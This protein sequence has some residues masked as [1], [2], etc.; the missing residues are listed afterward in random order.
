[1]ADHVAQHRPALTPLLD[2]FVQEAKFARQSI[3]ARLRELPPGAAILEVGAGLMLM[4]CHLRALGYEVHALEPIGHGFSGFAEL[5]D[6]VLAFARSRGVGPRV[7]PIPVEDLQ[8]VSRYDFAFSLNVMEHVGSVP[9]AIACVGRAL[10]PGASYL[11]I[12]PNYLFPYEPHFNMP[13]LGSKRLTEKVLGRRI[14]ASKAV[15][16]PQGTWHSLNWINVLQVGRVCRKHTDLACSFDRT[17]LAT[18]FERAAHDPGFA[19]R[20]GE[21]IAWVASAIVRSGLS[22]ALRFLPAA[23]QPVMKCTLTKAGA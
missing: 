17:L 7:L 16:D 19:A 4:S 10:R 2:V 9:E 5:Q 6:V 11:F 18:F 21:A 14:L 20:R 8:E 3:D 13:T 12:C 15:P 23:L 1:M 22:R